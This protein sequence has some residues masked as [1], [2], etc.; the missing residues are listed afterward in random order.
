MDFD[1]FDRHAQYFIP[2]EYQLKGD[3][4]L[5]S[6]QEAGLWFDMGLG[7]TATTLAAFKRLKDEGKVDCMLVV[8]TV[9]IAQT[10]WPNEL[11][12]WIDFHQLSY[13][14]LQGPNRAQLLTKEVDIYIINYENLVWLMNQPTW[15]GGYMRKVLCFDELSKMKNWSSQRVRAMREVTEYGFPMLAMFE[16]RWGLTGTPA[17]NGYQDLFA[18]TY[19][20]DLGRRL[21]QHKTAF[22]AKYFW[23]RRERNGR[24]KLEP[25][26]GAREE[27]VSLVADLYLRMDGAD[28]LELP[29]QVFNPIELEL[30]EDLKNWYQILEQE[31]I[32]E[33]AENVEI[34]A[35]SASSLTAK[36]RQFLS[37]R[38]YG[39]THDEV[40]FIHNMKYDALDE[41]LEFMDGHPVLIGYVF[42]HELE[43]IRRRHPDA[44]VL[45]SNMSA[46]RAEKVVEDFNAGR[47][48][49]L[50]GHPKAIGHGL[51]LQEACS[52]VLF[53]S[54]DFNLDDYLQFIARV[55]R[56][57]QRQSCVRVHSLYFPNTIETHILSAL[58]KKKA[59]QSWLLDFLR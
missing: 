38:M 44:V 54:Y 13:V 26:T 52:D 2:R 42:Q 57:G 58:Q 49:K 31:F 5:Y 11:K 50:L 32:L 41:F 37:G 3:I 30:P 10:V 9:K 55:A 46:A 59:D 34:P 27:I 21:G 56:S 43:E 36:L 4:H 35:T 25:I 22:E 7:K 20:L 17:S 23:K 12:K 14:V 45:D 51:N 39:D 33:L 1:P 40:H 8:G 6:H 47:I 24:S 29:E 18:Q 19:M 16:Y 28:W 48:M 53:F 15:A